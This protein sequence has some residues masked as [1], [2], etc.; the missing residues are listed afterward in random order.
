MLLH[1]LDGVGANRNNL[2]LAPG[3]N[4]GKGLAQQYRREILALMF[5]VYFGVDKVNLTR[6]QAVIH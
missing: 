2:F 5:G 6:P 3:S 4:I 1:V